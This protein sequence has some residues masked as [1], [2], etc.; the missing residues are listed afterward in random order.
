MG[1]IGEQIKKFRLKKGYTQEKLGDI[2]GVT[3]KAVSKWERGGV[4]DAE[5]LPDIADALNVDVNS[6]YGREELDLKVLITKRLSSLPQ[7]EAF[8]YAYDMC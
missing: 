7:N 1:I 8:G 4:P 6:L 3:T 5:I 2:I